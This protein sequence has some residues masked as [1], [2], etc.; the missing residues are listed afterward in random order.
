MWILEMAENPRNNRVE[1][2]QKLGPKFVVGKSVRKSVQKSVHKSVQ[3][4]R[5]KTPS[6]CPCHFVIAIV[7]IGSVSA[8][9]VLKISTS[10]LNVFM[11]LMATLHEGRLQVYI[12][13][14]DG[15]IETKKINLKSPV[16]HFC[17]NASA[18][19]ESCNS[20]TQGPPNRGISNGGASR[21]GLVLPFLSFFVL[22]GTF[23]IFPGFSRFA[24]GWSGDFPDLSFSSFSAY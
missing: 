1:C 16:P 4:I 20:K 15:Q 14:R 13:S 23:P 21:S 19:F 5:P 9:P 18:R 11:G 2:L 24:R 17:E 7:P 6:K 12:C 8:R 10:S 22:F 3:K